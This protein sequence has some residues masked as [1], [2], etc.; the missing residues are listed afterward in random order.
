MFVGIRKQ[1]SWE[2]RKHCTTGYM[3]PTSVAQ[4]GIQE[5]GCD[6][7]AQRVIQNQEWP[8][9][10]THGLSSSRSSW[11]LPLVPYS[12]WVKPYSSH[13][14]TVLSLQQCVWLCWSPG[15]ILLELEFWLYD[16]EHFTIISLGLSF[17][18]WNMRKLIV[19]ILLQDK[20]K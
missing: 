20:I 2:L 17:L 10:L 12:S 19:S 13:N 11:F 16:V 18:V 4:P 5:L 8:T 3:W 1:V 15:I 6:L 9:R 14:S 7:G